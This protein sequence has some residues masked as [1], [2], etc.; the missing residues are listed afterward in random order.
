LKR[1]VRTRG[2][3]TLPAASTL[4]PKRRAGNSAR[5]R[6]SAGSGRLKGG[7][8][9]D[10]PPSGSFSTVFHHVCQALLSATLLLL[11]FAL[12]AQKP[13]I[14]VER[15]RNS[16]LP[17]EQREEV[18]RSFAAKDYAHVEDVLARQAAAAETAAIG[19]ELRALAGAVEFVHGRMERS[20]LAYGQS[21][22]M[23]PLSDP[24]RFTW[25]MALVNLGD[26]TAAQS[27]LSRLSD[28]HPNSPLYLYWLARIDY[29]RRLYAEAV[30]KLKRVVILDP[31]W[32]RAYDSLGLAL[33]MLDQPGEARE[34]FLKA[35]ELN[36]KLASPSGWPPHNLGALL[37]RLQQL[38]EAES[39]LR[40]SLRYDPSFAMA[41]YHLGRALEGEGRDSEAMDEY[42]AATSHDPVVVEAFYSLGLL[43]R[44]HERGPEADA[45][46]AE[47]K[48]RKAEAAQ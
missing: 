3:G 15:I 12:L 36:R 14:L 31:E 37:L 24:D 16:H 25:A 39:A 40:E 22:A 29:D 26:S 47:Y 6:L 19:A 34:A 48:R 8:G 1:A 38:K 10:W 28:S 18:A 42:R 27:Q 41:H 4:R 30:A 21:D 7:C 11:P 43:C 5:S 9:Q 13:D 17:T 20:A 32:A 35:V 46:F 44:R 33:D 23:A 2:A 45:A